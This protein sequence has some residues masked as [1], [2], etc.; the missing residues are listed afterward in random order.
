M[1]GR[2]TVVSPGAG[3]G[4]AGRE[5]APARGEAEGGGGENSFINKVVNKVVNI[6]FCLYLLRKKLRSV[7]RESAFNIEMHI[8]AAFS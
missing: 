2:S 6:F 8:N 1:P 5:D 4:R 3:G 7:P